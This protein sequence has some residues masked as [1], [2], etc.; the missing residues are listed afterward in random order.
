M[1]HR[2]QNI[3]GISYTISENSKDLKADMQEI[4]L[5]VI[6]DKKLPFKDVYVRLPIFLFSKFM[7]EIRNTG[8]A[9]REMEARKNF[10]L[11]R[12]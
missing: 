10:F 5:G 9:Y 1:T 2:F 4:I 7:D 12:F 8:L 6:E 11:I 3:H